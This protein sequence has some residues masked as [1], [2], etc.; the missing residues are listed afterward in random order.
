M[1]LPNQRAL[2]LTAIVVVALLVRLCV[3]FLLQGYVFKG[4][5]EYGYNN[6]MVAKQ[7]VLGEGFSLGYYDSGAPRP[8]AITPPGYVYF[9]ALMFSIFGVYS[10][11]AAIVIEVLQSLTAAVTCIV[12]YMLG[13]R[14]SEQVGILTAAAMAVYPPSIFF[15]VMR[16]GPVILVVLLLALTMHYLLKIQENLHYRD[17]VICGIVM[18]CNAL[19]E[20]AVVLFYVLSCV[21]LFLWSPMSRVAALKFSIIMGVVCF[22]CLLPWTIRNS[23]V[24]GSYVPLKSSMGRN[25][26]EGNTPYGTGVIHNFEKENLFSPE[27]YKKLRN[28]DELQADKMMFDKALYFI[29]QDPMRFVMSTLKRIFYFWSPI[30]P[31]RPTR[32]DM[33]RLVTYGPVLIGAIIGVLL[34]G[35]HWRVVSLV[36]CLFLAYPL[37]YYITHVSINRYKFI[38][39]P[40]LVLLAIYALTE[41]FEKIRGRPLQIING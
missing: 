34:A 3:M 36:L 13:K 10:V 24:F 26:L 30:N 19:F 6:T 5:H 35:K 22:V 28:T 37:P 27:D 7:L 20:P 31:Y 39:E 1:R 18:G 8:T 41:I 16:I 9:L 4:N 32:E 11:E 2:W 12:F 40:F 29:K 25:L 14:V 33:L 23:I 17:A 15:S 38:V 21:W